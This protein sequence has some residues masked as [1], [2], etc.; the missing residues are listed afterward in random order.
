MKCVVKKR[1]SSVARTSTWP[2]RHT[3]RISPIAEEHGVSDYRFTAGVALLRVS[4]HWL[5]KTG[6]AYL[7]STV[8]ITRSN[9]GIALESAE[10][11]G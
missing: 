7:M 11:P 6:S 8:I 2:V 9:C 1:S 4:G 10:W 5:K 3:W